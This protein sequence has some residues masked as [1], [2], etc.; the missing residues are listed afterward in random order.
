VGVQAAVGFA[1]ATVVVIYLMALLRLTPEQWR[2]FGWIIAG[3][4]VAGSV[5]SEVVSSRA[6]SR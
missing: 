6:R 1:S 3:F 2:L 4:A 5:F